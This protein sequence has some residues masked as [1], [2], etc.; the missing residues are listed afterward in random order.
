[1]LVPAELLLRNMHDVSPAGRICPS[2]YGAP[3]AGSFARVN[4]FDVERASRLHIFSVFLS[5][6]SYG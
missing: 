5:T 2:V 6:P 1:V 4:G 3:V